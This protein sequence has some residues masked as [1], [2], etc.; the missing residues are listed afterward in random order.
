MRSHRRP[1]APPAH[2]AEDSTPRR[3][4]H[5]SSSAARL[6]AR[7]AAPDPVA[8]RGRA[9]R[10]SVQAGEDHRAVRRRR[11][12]RRL[13]A[14]SRPEA[15][16]DHGPAVPHREPPRRGR[17][18]RHRCGREVRAR[19]LHAAD[20]VQHPDDERI[21]GAEQALPAHARPH[22]G[23]AGELLRPGDGRA[24]VGPGEQPARVH[25]PRQGAAEEAQLRLVGHRHALPHGRRAVQR[26]GGRGRSSTCR[27]RA[28]PARATTCSAARCT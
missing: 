21:A 27:T 24:S 28:A 1:R 15:H 12:G 17:G 22:G 13:R 23:R 20:D 5:A 8:V 18:D 2:K 9:G 25:R 6:R 4:F 3:S 10:V 7:R 26:D 14:L 19:R 16:R 11:P